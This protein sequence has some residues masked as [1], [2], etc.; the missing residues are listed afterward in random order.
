MLQRLLVLGSDDDLQVRV[1]GLGRKLGEDV[2]GLSF[3]W[4]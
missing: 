1:R 3:W 2:S 4:F